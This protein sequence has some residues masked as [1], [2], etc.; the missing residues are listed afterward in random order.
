[1]ILAAG[2][3][4]SANRPDSCLAPLARSSMQWSMTETWIAS[5]CIRLMIMPLDAHSWAMIEDVGEHPNKALL[6][7]HPWRQC[8]FWH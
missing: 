3:M 4:H 5:S 6:A 7:W 8:C 2:A 1:V